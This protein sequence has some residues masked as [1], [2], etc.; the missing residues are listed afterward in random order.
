MAQGLRR[1]RSVGLCSVSKVDIRNAAVSDFPILLEMAG[2]FLSSSPC[3][4]HS[5]IDPD[6][7]TQTLAVL[8][9][10]HLLIVAEI[11]GAVIGTAG[12][13]LTPTY[14]NYNELQGL[15]FF[16]WLEKDYRGSGAGQALQ[17]ELTRRAKERG[18]KFWH[19]VALENDKVESLGA[20][21][22]R[23]GFKLIERTYLKV[24]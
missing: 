14:W 13:M 10:S 4:E 12:A 8:I 20:L 11:D 19:M 22:K 21:Y 9:D 3:A 18:V 16:W 23:S 7:L 2:K 5:T 6:S 17:Y 24:F 15:E 1:F